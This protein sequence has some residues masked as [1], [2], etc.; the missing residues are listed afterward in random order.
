[1]E[2]HGNWKTPTPYNKKSQTAVIRTVIRK[3]TATIPVAVMF[4]VVI[5]VVEIP[6]LRVARPNMN[7]IRLTE[8]LLIKIDSQRETEI[9]RMVNRWKQG[10]RKEQDTS[11]PTEN[12]KPTDKQTDRETDT[13]S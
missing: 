1:M 6:P 13:Y 11:A 2:P 12:R 8:K 9:T 5:P 4:D 10:K 7:A 3:E